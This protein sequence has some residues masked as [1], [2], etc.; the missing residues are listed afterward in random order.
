[1]LS[2]LSQT[3]NTLRISILDPSKIADLWSERL[4]VDVGKDFKLIPQLEQWK[5][6]DTGLRWYEPAQAAGES[7]LYTQL[8]QYDW[9]YI[10]RKWEFDVAIS[11]LRRG[12]YV[13]EV[14]VG[15]G[16]FLD[17]CRSVGFHIAG[18]E[19]NPTAAQRARENGFD[20]FEEDL[21]ELSNRIGE[22][23]FDAICSFQVLEH[24]PRPREFLEGMLAN[25]KV[26]GQL[27]LSVPNAAV[28]RRIDPDNQDLLNLPPHH[29]SHWD[30]TVFLSL[31]KVFPVKVR[32]VYCEPMAS[33]HVA[34]MV[35]GYLRNLLSPLG[36]IL[37]RLLVNRYSTMPLQWILKTGLR[38]LFPGHTLL[39]ELEK[40]G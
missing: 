18:V 19:L 16:Y 40:I 11:L 22:E 26:G 31:Q 13:L 30:E 34:W 9:Y 21:L 23:Q 25:I 39:V 4:N 20:V 7:D 32:S 14:G 6:G 8:E 12:A 27:I 37:Q 10:P 1:M 3:K 35:T 5:C 28:M 15:F 29:M 38:K 24:V 2:P 36:P 17:S 33:Y